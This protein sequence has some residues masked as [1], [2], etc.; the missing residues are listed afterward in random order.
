VDGGIVALDGGYPPIHN[1]ADGGVLVAD[2]GPGAVPF[3]G[4]CQQLCSSLGPDYFEC[5]YTTTPS[6]A[7]AVS[8]AS[9][10]IPCHTGRR[11]AGIASEIRVA[12]GLADYF[13][14]AAQL[15][16][17]SVEAFRVLRDELHALGA[18]RRL[19][20]RALA[21]AGDEVRHARVMSALA[22]R[23]GGVPAPVRVE[24][25]PL[26]PLEE[27]ALENAVEGC[28]RETYG[29]L[30]ATWQASVA[31]DRRVRAAMARIA[32]DETRHAE[33]AWDVM[34]WAETRLSPASRRRVTRAMAREVA[35]IE[36]SVANEPPT[37]W[38]A[39]GHPSARESRAMLA[40]LRAS[41]WRASA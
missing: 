15:E 25:R 14:A 26:R 24:R 3:A 33:L 11:P 2:A 7:P 41:L 4:D 8:C 21:S 28:V 29:A 39:A 30:V 12:P 31:P 40:S 37:A 17:V 13:V 34:R 1:P 38:R 23:H 18:P 32:R 27:V 35:A 5:S 10:T 20:R 19:Q 22:R 16:A 36:R 9:Y 6:G